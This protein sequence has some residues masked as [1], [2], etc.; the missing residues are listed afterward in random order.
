MS[1]QTI[2]P[3]EEFQRQLEAMNP[4]A[5]KAI[6]RM[7]EAEELLKKRR[8]PLHPSTEEEIT[9]A[10]EVTI[11]RYHLCRITLLQTFPWEHAAE[12]LMTVFVCGPAT[13]LA[14]P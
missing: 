10:A 8:G 2:T 14:Q 13:G 5:A 6:K 11:R 9:R 7:V 1:C 3:R 12:K 4:E